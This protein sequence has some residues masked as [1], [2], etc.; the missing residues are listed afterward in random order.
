MF[1]CTRLD[2]RLCSSLKFCLIS[3][4]LLLWLEQQP[5]S[6]TPMTNCLRRTGDERCRHTL[7]CRLK[8]RTRNLQKLKSCFLNT[9]YGKNTAKIFF[10]C[11]KRKKY[12]AMVMVLR[13]TGVVSG[14]SAAPGSDIRH[15]CSSFSHLSKLKSY[16]KGTWKN[17][18]SGNQAWS[19]LLSCVTS[20][21]LGCVFL[22]DR[23]L[24]C[25]HLAP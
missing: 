7:A 2:K 13:T 14:S 4:P 16:Y 23:T 5:C 17:R 1:F 12:T 9:L 21:V 3:S 8:L 19:W 20:A 10:F 15:G 11:S 6:H 24:P 25:Y 22:L 18:A